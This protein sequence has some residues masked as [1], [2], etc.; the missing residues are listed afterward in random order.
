[1]G[2]SIGGMG[3]MVA[4]LANLISY[5][6]YSKDYSKERYNKLFYPLN[7]TLFILLLVV[8]III[9]KFIS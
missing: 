3:T 5:K 8:G 2:V 6:L 1:L 4:S 9:T 7:F